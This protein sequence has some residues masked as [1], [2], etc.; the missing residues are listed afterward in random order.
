MILNFVF[1]LEAGDKLSPINLIELLFPL[2][3]LFVIWKHKE[4]EEQV[5]LKA[6]ASLYTFI[7][8]LWATLSIVLLVILMLLRTNR[9]TLPDN[10]ASDTFSNVFGADGSTLDPRVYAL[11][12]VYLAIQVVAWFI[13][14]ITYRFVK[15]EDIEFK[16]F[17]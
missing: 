6:P 15:E 8:I 3:M 17:A 13:A 14:M 2:I 12:F 16:G 5:C 4:D 11:G 1:S 7:Y 10:S 9:F